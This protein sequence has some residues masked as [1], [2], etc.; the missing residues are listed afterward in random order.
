MNMTAKFLS[1]LMIVKPLISVRE[2]SQDIPKKITIL[3][4][5]PS[6]MES[7]IISRRKTLQCLALA[8]GAAIIPAET[9]ADTFNRKIDEISDRDVKKPIHLKATDGKKGKIG[10]GEISFK[11]DKSQTEGHPGIT[12]SILPVGILGARHTPIKALRRYAG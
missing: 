1:W 2:K 6:T 4:Y 9:Y 12:E 7:S 11:F 5:N 10:A 3:S 8:M